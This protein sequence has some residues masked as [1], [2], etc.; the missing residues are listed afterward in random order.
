MERTESV[1]VQVA[2]SFENEKIKEMGA[3][4]WNL[5][6]RQEIHEEGDAYGRPSYLDS[7]TYVVKTKVNQYVKLHFARPLAL[8]NIEKIKQIESEYNNLPFPARP[9][10]LW[11]VGLTAFCVLGLII[12]NPHSPIGARIFFAALAALCGYWVSKRMAKRRDA[13]AACQ[14]SARRSNELLE[15]LKSLT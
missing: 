5:Q 7:S 4:G 11:P 10:L 8:P 2:P 9:S 14:Q 6:G 15:Q 13:M 12:G 1:V 3:F